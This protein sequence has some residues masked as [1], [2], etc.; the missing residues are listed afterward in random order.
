MSQTI[1]PGNKVVTL[2]NV[3]EDTSEPEENY[4][5]ETIILFFFPVLIMEEIKNK[6]PGFMPVGFY[7]K[8]ESISAF[9]TNKQ[10][11][12]K[13]TYKSGCAVPLTAHAIYD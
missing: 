12:Q 10:K 13:L 7:H 5:N 4:E 11:K 6:R 8:R 3:H 9:S 1:I 2:W